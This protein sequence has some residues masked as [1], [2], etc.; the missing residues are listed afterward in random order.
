M[1]DWVTWGEMFEFWEDFE[2][3][4]AIILPESEYEIK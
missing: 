4:N 1:L 2:N 3:D